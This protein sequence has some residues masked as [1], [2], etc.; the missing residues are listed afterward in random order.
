VES[1]LASTAKAAQKGEF[2]LYKMI[3]RFDSTSKRPESLGK[4]L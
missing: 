2:E 3:T 1:L 4:S